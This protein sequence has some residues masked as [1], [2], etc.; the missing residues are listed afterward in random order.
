MK[1]SLLFFLAISR[2]FSQSLVLYFPLI[3]TAKMEVSGVEMAEKMAQAQEKV[4]VI[5]L[6]F[7]YKYMLSFFGFF[8][9]L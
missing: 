3:M 6:F 8:F 4:R 7:F 1:K 5:L 9:I 2:S